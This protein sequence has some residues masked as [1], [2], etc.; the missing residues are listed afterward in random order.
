[1]IIA[2]HSTA[3]LRLVDVKAGTAVIVGEAS[4]L[5]TVLSDERLYIR[6]GKLIKCCQG[7]V[8]SFLS[9]GKE[10]RKG[11]GA[12]QIYA[13][14]ELDRYDC[15]LISRRSITGFPEESYREFYQPLRILVRRILS[16]QD[17]LLFGIV[18]EPFVCKKDFNPI[19]L[20]DPLYSL[21]FLLAILNSRL[22][23]KLYVT[24]S[25]ISLKDDFR[26]TTLAELTNLKIRSIHFTTPKKD[27]IAAVE[28]GKH[29]YK[30]SLV[31]NDLLCITAFVDHCL[32]QN[33]K[34]SDVV[35]DILAFLAEQM[36]EMNKE[37]QKEIKGFVKWLESQLRIQLDKEGSTGIEAL[38]GKTQIK[39]YLG[40]YQKKEE[41]LPFEDFWKILEKNKM[42][43]QANL[44]SRELYENIRS[45]YEKSLSK[46]LPLKE[47]LRKTDWLIDQ[48]V[49]RLYGL[50]GEDIKIVEGYGEG[51]GS[52]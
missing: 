31:I 17:R 5:L 3:T 33:P 45:E 25:A 24:G 16:R 10:L 49:Y 41:H 38:T 20:S 36:I 15:N 47:K 46:L 7:P 2:A 40:D 27:R 11:E 34:Q 51:S 39:N 32:K 28:K 23:S 13:V 30:Q 9:L 18:T 48:I 22:I 14:L 4:P 43:I 6:L 50:T 8:E 19:V 35:H 12:G 29:L 1:L 26:Q 44:K 52:F 37:K 42:R 21:Y